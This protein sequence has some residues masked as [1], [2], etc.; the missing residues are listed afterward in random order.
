MT[1]WI[2]WVEMDRIKND[3]DIDCILNLIQPLTEKTLLGISTSISEENYFLIIAQIFIYYFENFYSLHKYE[4]GI[5]I[6]FTVRQ[7]DTYPKQIP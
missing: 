1:H 7:G 4:V 3:I 5:G 6:F 2:F